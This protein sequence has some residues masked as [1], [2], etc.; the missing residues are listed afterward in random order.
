MIQLCRIFQI[1]L[2]TLQYW[3]IRDS[4]QLFFDLWR[5]GHPMNYGDWSLQK[6]ALNQLFVEKVKIESEKGLR[7]KVQKIE[8]LSRKA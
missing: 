5:S 8:F 2:V 4:D 7:R 1:S 6:V 3:I